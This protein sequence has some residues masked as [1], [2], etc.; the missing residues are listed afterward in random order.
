MASGIDM[1]SAFDTIQRTTMI[2]ILESFLDEDEVRIIRVLLSNTVLEI[3]T[4]DVPSDPFTTNIGSPQGDG[5]SGCL[6][7]IYLEKALRTLRSK[8]D[9][10]QIIQEH[11]YATNVEKIIPDELIYADDADFCK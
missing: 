4:H 8:L 11:C 1:T 9:N 3:K 6:F 5:L 2:E 10:R 7:T